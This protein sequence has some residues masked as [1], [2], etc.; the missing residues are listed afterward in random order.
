MQSTF[1]SFLVLMGIGALWQLFSESREREAIRSAIGAIVINTFLPALTFTVLYRAPLSAET[2]QIPVLSMLLCLLLLA[3]AFGVYRLLMMTFS[4]ILVPLSQ[5]S[6]GALLLATA[7]CNAT[8]LGLPVITLFLGEPAARIP[9]LFDLLALTPLL[10]TFGALLGA[11]FGE[12]EK[13]NLL[14]LFRTVVKLPPLWGAVL[15]LL[16]NALHIPLPEFLFQALKMG[17]AIVSPLMIFS[18]GL[19][20]SFKPSW[21]VLWATPAILLKLFVSPFIAYG[22]SLWLGMM[23]EAHQGVVIEAAMPSMVL[24]MVLADRF[25]LDSELLAQTIA[26]STVCSFLSLPLVWRLIS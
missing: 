11:R 15:G 6:F 20:L 14:G 21:R 8:Y 25:K 18:V 4:S 22:L 26:L 16:F 17:G 13:Q 23:G 12:G 3:I 24:T 2:W 7:W 9:I 10:L 5:G 1:F 19:A